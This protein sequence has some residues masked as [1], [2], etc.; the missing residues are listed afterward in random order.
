MSAFLS[1][2]VFLV[3]GF[4]IQ[5]SPLSMG[6]SVKDV[7]SKKELDGLVQSGVPVVLHFW[8]SWCEASKH[9]DEV[10]SHLST[11]FPHAH[12]LRVRFLL[13]SEPNLQVFILE[14]VSP[15]YFSF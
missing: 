2:S 11:D 5:R 1:L 3:V 7:Q 9:M 15:F 8:A 13:I 12:F 4:R 6:G 14:L 10:F